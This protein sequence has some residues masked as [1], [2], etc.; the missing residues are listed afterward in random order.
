MHG[1]CAIIAVP[2]RGNSLVLRLAL[3]FVDIALH[4]R[5][6]DGLPA[7]GLLLAI[8]VAGYLAAAYIALGIAPP[9]PGE[10]DAAARALEFAPL[11]IPIESAVYAAFVW[12]VLKSFGRDRRFVQTAS[13][14]FGTDA[15][16][17]LMSLPLLAWVAALDAA[18]A[19][20]T[21]PTL[22]YWVLLFWSID[23]SGFVLARAIERPYALAV[24]I[25]IGYV[26]LNVSVRASLFG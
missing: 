14:L 20:A 2:D 4:R 19:A 5:G 24:M 10:S 13:A 9:P 21:V 22:L 26:L 3:A 12:T 16:F 23:V 15:L 17:T 25:V 11:M 8:V 18:N 1:A 7:S 6:P